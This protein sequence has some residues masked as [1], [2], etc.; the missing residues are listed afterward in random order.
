MG[1]PLINGMKNEKELFIDAYWRDV[2]VN[3]ITVCSF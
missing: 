2:I 3:V 1:I